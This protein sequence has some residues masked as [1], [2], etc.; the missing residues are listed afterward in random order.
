MAT[1]GHVEDRQT[2]VAEAHGVPEPEA[3]I[4]RP[5]VTQPAYRVSEVGAMYVDA[6]IEPAESGDAA[7]VRS[8]L[9]N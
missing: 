7:H 9:V 4:V 5:A 2:S 6:T 3:L 8:A 1:P